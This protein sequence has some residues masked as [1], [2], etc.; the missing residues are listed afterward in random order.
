ME[1]WYLACHKTGKHHSFKVQLLLA[2]LGVEVFIPQ[3]CIRQPRLDRPGHFRAVLEP[4]FPGYL[5]ICFDPEVMHTS[6]ISACPGMS[7][8]VRFGGVIRPLHEAVVDEVM[9]LVLTVNADS[10][11]LQHRALSRERRANETEQLTASQCQQIERFIDEKDGRV[12]CA[13]FYA[14]AESIKN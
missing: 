14:L 2:R 6:K 5:F 8:L 13:L 1:Q 10:G 12:R 7:H 9:K 3:V 11:Q 4:L